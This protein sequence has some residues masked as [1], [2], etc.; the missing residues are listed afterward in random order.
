MEKRQFL[1]GTERKNMPVLILIDLSSKERRKRC[2]LFTWLYGRI[3]KGRII[4]ADC[5]RGIAAVHAI[6]CEIIYDRCRWWWCTRYRH[7]NNG[8]E[9]GEDTEGY[10]VFR[11]FIKNGNVCSIY[12]KAILAPR[13][14][15]VFE[16]TNNI[17]SPCLVS[18]GRNWKRW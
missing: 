13:E 18:E 5:R 12:R 4:V 6:G 10:V 17:V 1:H 7:E 2:A 16:G 11:W 15:T 9:E 3:V 8:K 14:E